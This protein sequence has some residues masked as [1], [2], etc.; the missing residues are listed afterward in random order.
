MDAGVKII[1]G[2]IALDNM[3]A[4]YNTDQVEAGN[5]ISGMGCDYIKETYGDNEVEVAMLVDTS[6]S[7]MATRSEAMKETLAKEC[8][9]ALL[10]KEIE[11]NDTESGM[12][13]AENIIQGNHLEQ[14]IWE[15]SL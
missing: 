13:A 4:L 12:S 8:P 5:T 10:V 9:N 3:N 2:G 1:S 6:N 14:L 11:A 7:N 15:S